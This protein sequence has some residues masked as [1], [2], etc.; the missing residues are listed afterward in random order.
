MLTI[1][2]SLTTYANP[3]I[4]VGYGTKPF[5]KVETPCMCRVE[6]KNSLA[7]LAFPF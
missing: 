5:L 4:G 1:K 2:E 7:P 6:D 3:T